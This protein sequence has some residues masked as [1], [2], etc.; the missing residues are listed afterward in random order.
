VSLTTQEDQA[1]AEGSAGW[2]RARQAATQ[3]T[4]LAK[5]AS[6]TAAQGVQDAREWA[7]PRI[8]QGIYQAREWAA[9][10]I[11]QAGH[12]VEETVAPKVS[13]MLTATAQLV[14][15]SVELPVEP[16][17]P[18][19]KRPLRKGLIV[20]LAAAVAA[21]GVIVIILRGR[22]AGMNDV[23]LVDEEVPED[24]AEPEASASDEP[25]MTDA[26]IAGNG[27]RAGH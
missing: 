2:D 16:P 11:D 8:A 24:A 10:R 26:G 9:P 6:A 17:P 23:D 25:A 4:V 1:Q 3:A 21:C 7:A 19:A 18:T 22:R 5:N 14:D 12:T 27:N 15:P 13:E 20:A